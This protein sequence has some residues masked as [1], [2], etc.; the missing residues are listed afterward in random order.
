MFGFPLEPGFSYDHVRECQ[1]PHPNCPK[2]VS[3]LFLQSV[4]EQFITAHFR[5]CA[6]FQWFL[7]Q[8]QYPFSD[9][10]NNVHFLILNL[11]AKIDESLYSSIGCGVDPFWTR[12]ALSGLSWPS[13]EAHPS[14][15]GLWGHPVAPEHCCFPWLTTE[16][17]SYIRC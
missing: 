2:A 1:N 3:T 4:T 17:T 16:T 13:D 12:T 5:V 9:I 15:R 11:H 6:V 14:Q 10:W 8:V 7:W